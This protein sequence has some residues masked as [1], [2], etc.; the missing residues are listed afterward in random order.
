MGVHEDFEPAR[1]AAMASTAGLKHPLRPRCPK[2]LYSEM[3]GL[4]RH[5]VTAAP[6]WLEVAWR[7]A[8]LWFRLAV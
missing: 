4:A 6:F 3:P 5:I 7:S 1:N 2:R 8:P